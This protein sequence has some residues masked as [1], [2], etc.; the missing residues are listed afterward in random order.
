MRRRS[1]SPAST[2]R[3]RDCAQLDTRAL[4]SASSCARSN[5]SAAVRPLPSH[6]VRLLEQRR[7]VHERTDPAPPQL[8][9]RRRMAGAGRKRSRVTVVVDVA[10]VLRQPVDKLQRRVAERAR[11]HRGHVSGAV[12]GQAVELLERAGQ[13]GGAPQAHP[14]HAGQ[15]RE[16]QRDHAHVPH[17]LDHPAGVVVAGGARGGAGREHDR[18]RRAGAE[19]RRQRAPR[20]RG[21]P[22]PVDR[23]HDDDPD[24][25]E[26]DRDLLGPAQRVGDAGRP[27]RGQERRRARLAADGMDE[28]LVH[29][30]HVLIGE[31]HPRQP[32]RHGDDV[33][34]DHQRAFDAAFEPPA[35]ERQREV[36]EHAAHSHDDASPIVCATVLESLQRS[37]ATS[38]A[39]PAANISQPMRGSAGPT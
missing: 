7:I 12:A 13:P 32:P 27:A 14:E 8:D 4:R 2:S 6:H 20:H 22:P 29:E 26:H 31:H 18:R 17:P 33:G 35:G 11:Q 10:L 25:D 30:R 34:G 36:R 38:Q 24:R 15:E 16:R 21:P 5:H 39:R 3:A 19:H 37:P 9:R 1:T 28:R 23:E